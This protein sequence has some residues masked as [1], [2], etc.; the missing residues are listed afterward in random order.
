MD[1]NELKKED[2]S[3][4]NISG[5]TSLSL[6]ENTLTEDVKNESSSSSD[7]LPF[8]D[9]VDGLMAVANE[10]VLESVPEVNDTAEMSSE[11]A[12]VNNIE[13]LWDVPTDNVVVD[14]ISTSEPVGQ[15]TGN[16]SEEKANSIKIDDFVTNDPDLIKPIGNDTN[17]FEPANVSDK[18]Y[19]VTSY[20]GGNSKFA[21]F[22]IIAIV[23]IVLG[24]A[25]LFGYKL[26]VGN[27]KNL[28][29][30]A[31]NKTQQEFSNVLNKMKESETLD[32]KEESVAIDGNFQITSNMP[33]MKDYTKHVYGYKLGLDVKNK[34]ME[35]KTSMK[36]GTK[37][38]IN[39]SMYIL[40]KTIYID[41][42]QVYNKVIYQL[43]DEDIFASLS[44]TNQQT[45]DYETINKLSEKLFGYLGN[46]LSKK[47]FDKE[48]ATIKINDKDVKVTKV[49]YNLNSESFYEMFKSM[50]E[51]MKDD[52]EFIELLSKMVGIEKEQ[53]KTSLEQTELS[54]EDFEMEET[55]KF[56]L[57][58][59][60]FIPKVIGYGVEIDTVTI[61]YAEL[62]GNSEFV[63]KGEGLEFVSKTTDNKSNGYIKVDGQELATFT[64]VSENKG[65]NTKAD[66][67]IVVKSGAS[68]ATISLKSDLIKENDRKA[69]GS[70]IANLSSNDLG[71]SNQMGF[72][73]TYNMEM[74]AQDIAS[75]NKTGAIN[76]STLTEQQL[77]QIGLNI[78]NA[79]KKTPFYS[80]V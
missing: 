19:T 65:N 21:I 52:D 75:F 34:K 63:L 78:E 49:I 2:I 41:S 43:L 73:L 70:I 10:P 31:I 1:N 20:S 58:T 80:G 13:T 71:T 6:E 74:G 53:V 60:G 8:V 30:A 38:I 40:G 37:E 15:N 9:E 36:E 47:S 25:A 17:S 35:F 16:S 45:I 59:N 50:I 22:G 33:E 61:S 54:K 24:V 11:P 7:D 77:Q 18:G 67:S 66:L 4:D 26:Y 29:K 14:S 5:D 28:Y 62:K 69:N 3:I 27:P 23:V 56:Y 42:K 12:E 76:Y 57:Y 39:A 32:L 72:K 46:S 64:L 68:S 55:V 44:S 79:L 51:E 48:N